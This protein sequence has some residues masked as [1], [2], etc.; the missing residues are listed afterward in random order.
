MHIRMDLRQIIHKPFRAG[1]SK[2][3][4]ASRFLGKCSSNMWTLP[5]TNLCCC[6]NLPRFYKIHCTMTEC[7]GLSIYLSF[8]ISCTLDL[9]ILF[10]GL[11][12]VVWIVRMFAGLLVLFGC[13]ET[14]Q[15]HLIFSKLQLSTSCSP[16]NSLVVGFFIQIE[17]YSTAPPLL[18]YPLSVFKTTSGELTALFGV[19]SCCIPS[20]L[21]PIHLIKGESCTEELKDATSVTLCNKLGKS[22]IKQIQRLHRCDGQFDISKSSWGKT[23]NPWK[24]IQTYWSCM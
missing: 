18:T 5:H 8:P 20:F 12:Y 3:G 24:F 10:R 9:F 13:L 1:R 4:W 11:H 21:A 7:G 14:N 6:I 16:E 23:G 15:H 17:F 19:L 22:T 2:G